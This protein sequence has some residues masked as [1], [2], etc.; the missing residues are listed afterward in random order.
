MTIQDAHVL[1]GHLTSDASL[2]DAFA[3]YQADRKK[4]DEA[5]VK[6]ARKMG[7][8][9]MMHSPIATWLRDEAFSHVSPQK[10]KAI[11]DEIAKGE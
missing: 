7:H 5:T 3:G 4:R 10:A 1:I 8:L 6:E 11:A 2:D 9:A